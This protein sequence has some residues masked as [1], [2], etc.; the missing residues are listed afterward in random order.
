MT[1]AHRATEP[2]V[3]MKFTAAIVAAFA[4]LAATANA[5]SEVVERKLI[6]GGTTVPKGR[7][8]YYAGMRHTAE[9]KNFCGGTLI[10]P[11]HVLTASHCISYDIRWV[12]IGSHYNNGTDDGEQI[13]VVAVMNHPNFTESLKFSNDFAILELE[14]PSTI[15]PAKLAKA[16]G[17]DFKAGAT[18]TTVGTGRLSEGSTAL[19]GHKLQRVDSTLITNEECATNGQ[20]SVDDSMIC[21]GGQI[22]KGYC[23]GD[24]GARPS[25]ST[26]TTMPTTWWLVWLAGA[27]GATAK[28]AAVARASP[29]STPAWHTRATGSTPSASP[30]ASTRLEI[31]QPTVEHTKKSR[32]CNRSGRDNTICL[33]L[34]KVVFLSPGCVCGICRA[35]RVYNLF[36][37][38]ELRKN[39]IGCKSSRPATTA[40][41]RDL[42]LLMYLS[43]VA[44]IG[45]HDSNCSRRPL[46]L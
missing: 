45:M 4:T 29:W 28:C 9:G 2:A 6:L 19:A 38:C 11:T 8:T 7:K 12:S 40:R 16:D 26:W 21:V 34:L 33:S 42:T 44:R 3:E 39:I 37:H 23:D 1:A 10:S 24:S 15:T 22:S 35:L 5:S 41:R 14:V 36:G 13:K 46:C 20:I 43:P 30:R 17:S 31:A 32:R 27:T 18:V 25:S